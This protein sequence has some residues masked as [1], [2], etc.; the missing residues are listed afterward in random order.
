MRGLLLTSIPVMIIGFLEFA[1][2]VFIACWGEKK[3]R[4]LL[5]PQQS[6][7]PQKATERLLPVYGLVIATESG[8]SSNPYITLFILQ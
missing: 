3:S 7:S 8:I 1:L 6:I 5:P 2:K 4:C